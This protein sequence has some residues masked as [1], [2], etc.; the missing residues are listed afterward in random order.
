MLCIHRCIFITSELEFI[1][2]QGFVAWCQ[3]LKLQ[4]LSPICLACRYLSYFYHTI[5]RVGKI[6]H[7][8]SQPW[9]NGRQAASPA[10]IRV[11]LKLLCQ[12]RAGRVAQA[13]LWIGRRRHPVPAVIPIGYFWARDFGLSPDLPRRCAMIAMS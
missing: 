6:P 12:R 2:F 11:Q 13:A 10:A 4:D 7:R 9:P 1:I 3:R 8:R 5:L